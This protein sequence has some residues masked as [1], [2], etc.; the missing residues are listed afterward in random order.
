MCLAT[1]GPYPETSDPGTFVTQLAISKFSLG[2]SEHLHGGPRA[3]VH[4]NRL[5]EQRQLQETCGP[6][7]YQTKALTSATTFEV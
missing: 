6:A 3:Q 4:P 1:N 7:Q 2:C 5:A